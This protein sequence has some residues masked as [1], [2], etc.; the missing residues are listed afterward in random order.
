MTFAPPDAALEPA[1]DAVARELT[2]LLGARGVDTS[3]AMRHRVSVDQAGMSPVIAA[4]PPKAFADIVV[5]PTT[6]DEVRGAV[7]IA[8]RERI[9]IIARGKGTGNYGQVLPARG[10][11]VIDL[12]RLKAIE[13]AADGTITAQ[14]GARMMD[15]ETRANESGQELWI[16]PSTV[17]STIGGFLAGGSAGTGTIENGNTRQGFV[18]ALDV[19][20]AT[21]DADLVHVEGDSTL[22]Y[23]HSFGVTGIIVA[24]TIR[25]AAQHDWRPI[26]ASFDSLTDAAL[27]L[28]TIG[29]ITPSPRL[30]SVDDS[31]LA[32]TLPADDALHKDRASLRVLAHAETVD[33]VSA[34][35]AAHGGRVDAIR[36]G[37]REI[38]KMSLISYN[39]P[40]WWFMRSNPGRYFHLEVFGEDIIDRA[41]EIKNMFPGG[42]LHLELGHS[43]NFG[44][45]VAEYSDESDVPAA[46]AVLADLGVPAH[47][48]HEWFIDQRA[49]ELRD[50]AAVTDPY[51]LL[52][53][54]KFSQ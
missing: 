42:S 9:P 3:P 13:P 5:F 15:L 29:T 24:A 2:D 32:A 44:M 11:I 50:A 41:E 1:I 39:H 54:G 17:Q 25:L 20:H 10:G 31:V 35:I 18:V 34:A 37:A 8:V 21:A 43:F 7:R 12:T 19:I 22:P 53:P 49:S 48:N 28:R 40:T 26:Y 4:R 45:V 36:D 23:L 30:C 14:A 38:L 16:Y 51:G 52:N 6:V 33:A 46:M 27:C 47:N